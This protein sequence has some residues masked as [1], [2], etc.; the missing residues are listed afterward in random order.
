MTFEGCLLIF[1]LFWPF[2][3]GYNSLSCSLPFLIALKNC[4]LS[5]FRHNNAPQLR[6]Y[7]NWGANMSCDY[8]IDH[9]YF[10]LFYNL[11]KL[12]FTLHND[13][14]YPAIITLEKQQIFTAAIYHNIL[15]PMSGLSSTLPSL[16]SFFSVDIFIYKF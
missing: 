12:N 15:Q 10:Y 2:L 5:T 9:I 4:V 7:Q 8:K 3:E 11:F 1:A 14:F 16:N 13:F 6:L